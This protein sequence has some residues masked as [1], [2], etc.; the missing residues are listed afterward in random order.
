MLTV[1]SYFYRRLFDKKETVPE[2]LSHSLGFHPERRIGSRRGI[3]RGSF[4]WKRHRAFR[5][6]DCRLLRAASCHFHSSLRFISK[7]GTVTAYVRPERP[8]GETLRRRWSTKSVSD[9]GE[10]HCVLPTHRNTTRCETARGRA[11]DGKGERK[12]QS[13]AGITLR[14]L[15]RCVVAT[16]LFS[17]GF[18][19]SSCRREYRK[20]PFLSLSLSYFPYSLRFSSGRLSSRLIAARSQGALFFRMAKTVHSCG[21]RGGE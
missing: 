21:T 5:A 17:A 11:G 16:P 13:T 4:L 9:T 20:G 6:R 7:P 18:L 2:K 15:L 14:F 1:F 8:I 3:R 12:W 10:K 19:P